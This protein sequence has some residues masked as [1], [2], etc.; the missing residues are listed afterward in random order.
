MFKVRVAV[1]F[2]IVKFQNTQHSL[3]DA[4]IKKMFV[5]IGSEKLPIVFSKC[6]II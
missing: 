4:M 3:E 5:T 6:R 2:G 1:C